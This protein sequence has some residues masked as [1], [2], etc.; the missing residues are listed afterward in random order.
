L[1]DEKEQNYHSQEHHLKEVNDSLELAKATG[2]VS[3]NDEQIELQ[4]TLKKIVEPIEQLYLIRDFQREF[5]KATS[6]EEKQRNLRKI[7]ANLQKITEK[8][9]LT[10]QETQIQKKMEQNFRLIQQ[11][12]DAQK[13]ILINER[14][15]KIELL[16]LE[17]ESQGENGFT[18]ENND[19]ELISQKSLIIF[20]VVG[21][22]LIFL[23]R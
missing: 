17:K 10:D 9:K 8:R 15:P 18:T 19:Q 14:Q 23:Y 13:F 5:N 11:G 20:A 22:L 6:T 12:K 21:F 4:R 16:T 3:L 2:R 7:Q 1:R